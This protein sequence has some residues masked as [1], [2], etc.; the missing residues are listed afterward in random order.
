MNENCEQQEVSFKKPVDIASYIVS[1]LIDKIDEFGNRRKVASGAIL[2]RKNKD[3]FDKL[4]SIQ[5]K[6]GIDMLGYVAF[7]MRE[8]GSMNKDRIPELID[9]SNISRYAD[10]LVICR[11]HQKILDNFNKSA[12][13]II[14]ES[15]KRHCKSIKACVVELI[16]ENKLAVL[17]LTGRL[18]PHYLAGLKNFRKIV[19]RLDSISKDTLLPI[20]EQQEQLLSDLRDAFMHLKNISVASSIAYT[21]KQRQ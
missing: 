20:A 19:N 4:F 1:R 6:Y 12:N 2:Y 15:N 18:S 8:H 13:F 5:E 9:V 14:D 17:Y 11:K 10:D 21:E 7:F 3:V 16:L